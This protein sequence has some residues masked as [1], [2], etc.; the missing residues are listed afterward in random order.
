VVQAHGVGAVLQVA[1]LTAESVAGEGTT[2]TVELA[3]AAEA[4][5]AQHR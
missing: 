3:A 1:S 2:F 4:A 5:P